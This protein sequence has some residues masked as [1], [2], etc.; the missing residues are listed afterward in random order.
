MRKRCKSFSK[1]DKCWAG[2]YYYEIYDINGVKYIKFNYEFGRVDRDLPYLAWMLYEYNESTPVS[3]EKFLEFDPYYQ[4]SK[5]LGKPVEHLFIE[6]EP[7][8]ELAN[9]LLTCDIEGNIVS[10]DGRVTLNILEI[11]ELTPCD[12]YI[13]V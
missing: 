3:L 2:N 11:N 13:G 6:P 10:P 4:R 5:I 8:W 1:R 9:K 7:C 12:Y